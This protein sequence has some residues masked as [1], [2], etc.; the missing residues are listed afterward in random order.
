MPARMMMGNPPRRATEKT[1]IQSQ[2][3]KKWQRKRK[4][5]N[6]KPFS[7]PRSGDFEEVRRG[8]KN[9]IAQGK[10]AAGERHLGE[11]TRATRQAERRG[12]VDHSR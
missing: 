5:V 4:I 3:P 6:S 11:R 10:L 2:F 8:G 1:R 7:M 12:C 9:S